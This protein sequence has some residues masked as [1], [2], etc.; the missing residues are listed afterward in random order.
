[1]LQKIWKKTKRS[2]WMSLMKRT[3]ITHERTGKVLESLRT[4]KQLN[5]LIDIILE[6]EEYKKKLIFRNTKFQRNG[7]L[8]KKIKLELEERC[9]TRNERIS[10]TVDQIRS[11][12]KKLVSECKKVA[13][14]IKTATGIKWFLDDKGYGAWFDKLFAI[15]K[16]RD[17]CQPEQAIEPSA[18]EDQTASSTEVVSESEIET[19]PKRLYVPV[20]ERKRGQKDDSVCEAVKLIRC[21]VENDPTKEIIN[22][23]RED[24]QKARQHELQL[25][26]MLS[27]GN[28][29][30]SPPGF[31]TPMASRN[32]YFQP[33]AFSTPL[34]NQHSHQGAIE[35]EKLILGS[36]TQKI[37]K[38]PLRDVQIVFIAKPVVTKGS[39][40][41]TL[42]GFIQRYIRE[43]RGHIIGHQ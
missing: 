33:E 15:V 13:L 28:W 6:N 23:M 34:G 38:V 32:N 14:T 4:Q 42:N 21:I 22:F 19:K 17:S 9:G 12:F 26:Q 29:R 24:A 20:K 37:D 8:Y 36:H 25:L 10:L 27:H 30:Q 31:R 11:K 40:R 39:V 18:L 2:Y 16:T 43:Q 3:A 5:D 7:E 41:E 1:M 35:L